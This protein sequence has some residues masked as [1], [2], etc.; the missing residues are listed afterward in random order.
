MPH[1]SRAR[2]L[3]ARTAPA[4]LPVLALAALALAASFALPA[5]AADAEPGRQLFTA[6]AMPPCALCHTL[7]DAEATGTVGPS[8]DDLKPSADQVRAAVTR[9][10]GVMP[11]YED[12]STEQVDALAAYV[13]GVAGR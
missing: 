10:V 6:E 2:R 9:G 8:L 4:A 11:P 12:L 13:S 5:R 7:A 1:P 3:R